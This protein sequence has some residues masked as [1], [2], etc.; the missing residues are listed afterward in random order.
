MPSTDPRV[1]AY[2][3]KSQDFA[4]P[5]LNHIRAL[6]HAACPEATETMKWSFPHFDYKGEM[7]CSM[8]A[9]K[10]HCA[11]GFWKQSLLENDAFPAEKTAMGSFGRL[12]SVKD[13][14][15]DKVMKKLIKDAMK[16]NDAGIKVQ[17]APVSKDKKELVVPDIL[18]ES[19]A[20][21]DAAA[22]TFSS[23][24]YSKKKDYVVWITEAKSD[25]TRDK[26]LATTIEWLAEGKSRMWKY[27]KC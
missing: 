12:T 8:A 27:E 21:N 18:L 14:P 10:A 7:M 9:F 11:F 15:S 16:L 23:F 5:I 19:L 6:V 2:I 1:D 13:L 17:R 24:P 25:A 4:K 20:K 3:E 22:E 26:R